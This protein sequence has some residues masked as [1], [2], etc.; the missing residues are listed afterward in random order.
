MTRLYNRLGPIKRLKHKL[1][2]KKKIQVKAL[3]NTHT[4]TYILYALTENY[5]FKKLDRNT[6]KA[7]RCTSET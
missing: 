5:I 6:K 7:E 3:S 2:K 1:N 4:H